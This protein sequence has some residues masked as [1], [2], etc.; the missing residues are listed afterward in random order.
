MIDR[1]HV[2]VGIND[3]HDASAA[4][5]IGGRLVCAMSEERFQRIK[6][7]GGFPKNAIEACLAVA[8]IS[9]SDVDYVAIGSTSVS[10]DNMHNIVPTLTIRDLY[11]IEEEYW[12][13][14]IYENKKRRLKD[15]FPDY[16]P[17]GILYYPLDTVPF[18]FSRELSKETVAHISSVRQ[19]YVAKYFGLPTDKVRSIDHHTADA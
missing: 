1:K 15:V 14:V 5:I 2:I 9:K 13:P 8:G 4:V 11:K 10:P 19:H 16:K 3:S 18:A 7:M 12:Q 17:K 6:S